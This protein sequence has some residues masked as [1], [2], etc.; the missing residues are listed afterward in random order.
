MMDRNPAVP[1]EAAIGALPA[2]FGALEA[3]KL[4]STAVALMQASA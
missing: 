1:D 3:D 4:A 2:S